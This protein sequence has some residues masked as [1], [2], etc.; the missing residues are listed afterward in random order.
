MPSADLSV[1]LKEKIPL[2]QIWIFSPSF[3]LRGLIYFSGIFEQSVDAY[4]KKIGNLR[5]Q[6]NIGIGAALLPFRY[7][8]NA[9]LKLVC[10][11]ALCQS[12]VGTKLSYVCADIKDQMCD[13]RFVSRISAWWSAARQKR[14]H[15]VT[16]SRFCYLLA[17]KGQWE[18]KP[19][20]TGRAIRHLR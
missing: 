8:L 18:L 20:R 6:S 7:C 3:A 19:F 14:G 10:Q 12:R 11:R 15:A 16:R 2:S 9:D 1:W 17:E 13:L 4:R 5:K